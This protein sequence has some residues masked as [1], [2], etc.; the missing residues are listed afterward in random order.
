MARKG[1]SNELELNRRRSRGGHS[2]QPSRE[3]TVSPERKSGKEMNKNNNRRSGSKKTSH[4][5][6]FDQKRSESPGLGRSRSIRRQSSSKR[7]SQSQSRERDVGQKRSESPGVGRSRSINK[8]RSSKRESR[9]QSRSTSVQK[10]KNN[11]RNVSSR[12]RSTGRNSH[13]RE[14]SL[15]SQSRLTTEGRSRS[16]KIL[17]AD[18]KEN[19]VTSTGKY[20]SPK[21]KRSPSLSRERSMSKERTISRELSKSKERTI[22]NGTV[23]AETS[24]R[25]ASTERYSSPKQVANSHSLL[26]YIREEANSDEKNKKAQSRLSKKEKSKSKSKS[27]SKEKK[28]STKA[29]S[30]SKEKSKSKER[31]LSVR[32]EFLH[33]QKEVSSSQS[34]LASPQTDVATKRPKK[35]KKSKSE[36]PSRQRASKN[37]GMGHELSRTSSHASSHLDVVPNRPD[38]RRSVSAVEGV[39]KSY[40]YVNQVRKNAKD[41]LFAHFEGNGT[42]RD[43]VS[44]KNKT[45]PTHSTWG[46]GGKEFD[47]DEYHERRVVKE[48]SDAALSVSNIGQATCDFGREACLT[49]GKGIEEVVET[50]ISVLKWGERE[51]MWE[52]DEEVSVTERGRRNIKWMAEQHAKEMAANQTVAPDI[53]RT[54]FS[55]DGSEGNGSILEGGSSLT[56]LTDSTIT[57]DIGGNTNIFLNDVKDSGNGNS[58]NINEIEGNI[59]SKGG[60]NKSASVDDADNKSI[61]SCGTASGNDATVGVSKDSESNAIVLCSKQASFHQNDITKLP[62]FV[63]STNG[64][65]T[66]GRPDFTKRPK[67]AVGFMRDKSQNELFSHMGDI[68]T[69]RATSPVKNL[70]YSIGGDISL[71]SAEGIGV[72]SMGSESVASLDEFR[73]GSIGSENVTNLD[74]IEGNCI[75]S[76]NVTNSDINVCSIT[77]SESFASHISIGINDDIHENSCIEGNTCIGSFKGPFKDGHENNPTSHNSS[78]NKLVA[79]ETVNTSDSNIIAST[80]DTRSPYHRNSTQVSLND[81]FSGHD[82]KNSDTHGAVNQACLDNGNTNGSKGISLAALTVAKD[83]DT[84]YN[85]FNKFKDL[86]N[87]IGVF[88]AGEDEL[89]E[90]PSVLDSESTSTKGQPSAIDAK[91]IQQWMLR[92]SESGTAEC[93]LESQSAPTASISPTKLDPSTVSQLDPS[94]V[95]R[96]VNRQARSSARS[97]SAGGWQRSRPCT[98]LIESPTACL[99]PDTLTLSRSQEGLD[100]QSQAMSEELQIVEGGPRGHLVG[101]QR[102]RRHG[103]PRKQRPIIIILQED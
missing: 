97:T 69:I 8:Q 86:M 44:T 88:N 85:S 49:L 10:S 13:S 102:R 35:L 27:K 96:P 68:F 3:K 21:Q 75:G 67:S 18:S 77:N 93:T 61:K 54:C 17:H 2:R 23:H 50:T 11:E 99:Q 53:L 45:F 82:E 37:N 15:Y 57:S 41:T 98:P 59:E 26:G 64:G 19:R 56:S 38:L 74:G 9:S 48:I 30:K 20:S 101:S 4:E 22:S 65:S 90:T 81:I 100:A 28:D 62:S 32:G 72:S 95:I 6:N 7:E 39:R 60:I 80:V 91:A 92:H 76:E 14:S 47:D 55:A 66:S 34:Y 24:G 46:Q 25:S 103:S 52:D 83:S 79:K 58:S 73:G 94:R 87:N 51:Y 31:E 42:I 84:S 5:R 29:R 89:V 33:K 63:G 70:E 40:L 1:N 43:T 71:Y 78:D 36:L 16:E 12:S